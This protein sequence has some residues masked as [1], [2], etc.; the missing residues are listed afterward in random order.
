MNLRILFNVFLSA[1]FVAISIS[2]THAQDPVNGQTLFLNN[3]AS[4]HNNNMVD[5]MTGPALA[6][7][8]DRW[9]KFPNDLYKW[10]RNSVSLAESGQ[11]YAAN[12]INWS[13]SQMTAF[14]NLDDASIDDILAYVANKAEFGCANP[15][16]V[17]AVADAGGA[18]A[19]E[20]ST[21]FNPWL[22]YFTSRCIVI[23]CCTP[24]SLH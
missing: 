18:A 2:S 7:V 23:V 17:D 12:M 10:I 21:E 14:E 19:N 15:P 3:C 4:C 8:Q 11:P 13:S 22:G 16:C 24:R 6:G 9:K 5:D 1:L 20:S